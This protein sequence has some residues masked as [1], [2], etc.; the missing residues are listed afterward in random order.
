LL[1]I[2]NLNLILKPNFFKMA[3]IWVHFS[4]GWLSGEGFLQRNLLQ[5]G[6]YTQ[7]E[8]LYVWPFPLEVAPV[9]FYFP[10]ED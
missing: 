2:F 1:L 10:L 8:H 5:R 3:L 6:G 4:P 9:D 7:K